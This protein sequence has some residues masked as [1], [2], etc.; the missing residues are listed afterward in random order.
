MTEIQKAVIKLVALWIICGLLVS[1]YETRDKPQ[2]QDI[3]I[4]E[5]CNAMESS[6]TADRYTYERYHRSEDEEL[7]QR[8]E[9]AKVRANKTA[10]D[11]NVFVEENDYPDGAKRRLDYIY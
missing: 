7:R 10:S 5:I 8:A 3:Q 1:V 2:E 9:Q 11:Y 6:Y 4:A